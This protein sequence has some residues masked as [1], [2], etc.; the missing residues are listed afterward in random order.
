[1]K[2]ARARCAAIVGL[3]DVARSVSQL[4]RELVGNYGLFFLGSSLDDWA[5]AWSRLVPS[6]KPVGY[7][8]GSQ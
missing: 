1:M 6:L 3:V 4:V 8:Y 7:D 5:P 2:R